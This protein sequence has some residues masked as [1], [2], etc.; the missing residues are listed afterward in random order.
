MGS[1]IPIRQSEQGETMAQDGG[2]QK[3]LESI[4]ALYRGPG[5][6][7]A[8]VKGGELAGQ[9][10]W[11]FASLEKRI[12]LTPST[13]FPICS[14]SK[15]MVCLILTELLADD[16]DKVFENALNEALHELLP[17]NLISNK[18]LTVE[19]LVGMQ[20]GLRDYWAL[21]VLWGAAPGDRF[22][23]YSDAPK[24]LQRL[25]DFH[26]APGSQMS[27]CNSNF[28]TIGLAIEKA[29][30]KTLSD[31]LETRLFKPAG[32]KTAALRPDTEQIPPPLVGYEGSES[33]GYIPYKN[34]I[35]WAG[36]AGIQASLEDMIAYEKYI[37]RAQ[38]D[39][40]S[41][42]RKNAQQ[43]HYL[44]GRK[45]HYGN[46]LTH[47]EAMGM[48]SVGH[49]GALAGFKL[50]RRYF[51]EKRTS[52]IVMLN[53]EQ[54]PWQI[55]GHALK[56][57]FT[58]G[59]KEEEEE[60]KKNVVKVDVDWTGAYL[61]EEAKIAVVVTQ[62]KPGEV[63]V[64]YDG[65]EDTISLKS[66]TEAVADDMTI[67]FVEGKLDIDR[68]EDGRKFSARKL[69]KAPESPDI[70]YTGNYRSEDVDSSLDC[71]G[72]GGMLY[73][74]FTGYLGSGPAH[75]MRH[76][77]EDVWHLSCYRSLDSTAP[78]TWTV[79]FRRGDDGK[80]VE[81]VTVGCWLARGV[82]YVRT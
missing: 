54:N 4:P 29:S 66:A 16:K 7:I 81:G 46:G 24:A 61:D 5:G 69:A 11:G 39:E 36:D 31:L 26:F 40:N 50:H 51:P 72:T 64:N 79:V 62:E 45:A 1:Q 13:I 22:S 12:P 21:S 53:W 75:L 58:P 57:L 2:I 43:P 20:S 14:I 42:Y 10:V 25:G 67:S 52:V 28:M 33:A 38:H 9:H 48:D 32:M 47:A 73:G 18:D 56:N 55:G 80:T 76:L 34:R 19:R 71:T 15:Q 49:G 63:V 8:I 68:I 6:A 35:E 60:K 37:D 23:I 77:G 65:H 30:G 59:W 17:E 3:I 70:D 44:D 74:S 82:K 78:G 41:A 27:Y